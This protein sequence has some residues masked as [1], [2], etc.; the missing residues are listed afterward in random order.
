MKRERTEVISIS[1][2]RTEPDK[3]LTL[4]DVD[5]RD[6]KAGWFECIY[7]F[8][9]RRDGLIEK[10]RDYEEPAMGFGWR[11]NIL[12]VSI[13]LVGGLG[14]P[15]FTVKQDESLKD[16]VMELQQEYP[17]AVLT[18]HASWPQPTQESNFNDDRSG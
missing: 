7:H 8:L 9:V 16:L 4:K 6:R 15:A 18:Y 14:E 17:E 13:C 12:T 3:N 10:A 5:L 11:R 1:S 2:T